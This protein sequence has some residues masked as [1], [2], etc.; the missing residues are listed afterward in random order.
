MNRWYYNNVFARNFSQSLP[1]YGF[2]KIKKM[3]EY[4]VFEKDIFQIAFKRHQTH[5]DKSIFYFFVRKELVQILNTRTTKTLT[6][7]KRVLNIVEK[8]KRIEIL[9]EI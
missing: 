1:L 3:S 5:E 7:A 6:L 4:Y 2:K 9:K 8:W